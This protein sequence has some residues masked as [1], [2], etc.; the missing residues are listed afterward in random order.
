MQ[1]QQIVHGE[2]AE[3]GA[4][5]AGGQTCPTATRV[6]GML[7]ALEVIPPE[8]H[9]LRDLIIL[10][11][12]RATEFLVR[13]QIRDGE[14]L[15]GMPRGTF[16]LPEISQEFVVSNARIDEVR[17]DYVQHALSAMIMYLAIGEDTP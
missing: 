5:R 13:A 1:P 17:I 11:C 7:A 6:E 9:P 15:G 16:I 8:Q 14:L 12:R 10:A 2:P 4:F 3:F